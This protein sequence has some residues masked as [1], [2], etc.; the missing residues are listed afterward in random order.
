MAAIDDL[1]ASV[2]Q[3]QTTTDAVLVKISELRD[4]PNNDPAITSASNAINDAVS[5]LNGAIL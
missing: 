4:K 2:G 1:N 5:K 3:L